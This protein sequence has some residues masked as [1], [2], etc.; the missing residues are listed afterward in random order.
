[1]IT[2]WANP[3]EGSATAFPVATVSP[4]SSALRTTELEIPWTRH[5]LILG[6][7]AGGVRQ[8]QETTLGPRDAHDRVED[9][10]QHLAQDQGR[11]QGLDELE[12]EL[13]VLDPREL[14]QLVGGA[15]G[16]EQRELQR[17]VA[18]LDL[19][20]R[21]NLR[22]VHLRRVHVDPVQ[23]SQVLEEEVSVLVD[24]ARVGLGDGRLREGEVVVARP[25]QRVGPRP[26]EVDLLGQVAPHH[27]E[28]RYRKAAFAV[29]AAMRVERVLL[30][31][32]GTLHGVGA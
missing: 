9:L 18:Q 13:L 3:S 16:S 4:D 12:Q 27:L 25:P 26:Q 22:P 29:N 6:C 24:D 21:R 2:L 15:F 30:P 19:S 7:F 31:A 14:G 17:H 28:D 10:F 11:V 5:R 20:S 23:A 32:L 1:M 8:Q